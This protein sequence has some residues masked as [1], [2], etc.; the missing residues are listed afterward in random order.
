[1]APIDIA[2]ASVVCDAF[3]LFP[4]SGSLKRHLLLEAERLIGI[5]GFS[6]NR[7]IPK[8]RWPSSQYRGW[9][10]SGQILRKRAR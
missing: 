6:A 9:L 10:A 3:A 2:A 4:L 1:M 7:S 5:D 8:D